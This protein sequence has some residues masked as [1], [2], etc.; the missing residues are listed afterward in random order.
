MLVFS[1]TEHTMAT[2]PI[3]KR[4]H[5]WLDHLINAA[6]TDGSLVAYAR[7]HDLKPKDLYLWKFNLD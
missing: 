1:Q 5:Y 6:S 4:Q 3:T 7:A 2:K